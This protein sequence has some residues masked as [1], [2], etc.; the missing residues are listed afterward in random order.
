MNM[1]FNNLI[2]VAQAGV[3][4]WRSA[5]KPSVHGVSAKRAVTAGFGELL[6]GRFS[7]SSGNE[8]FLHL[9][10]RLHFNAP[11]LHHFTNPRQ[12]VLSI[13]PIGKSN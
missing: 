9:V 7:L 10:L 12:L 8:L 6:G 3:F 13:D 4:L 11:T 1:A 2:R 5:T